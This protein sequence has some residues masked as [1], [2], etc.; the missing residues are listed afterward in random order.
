MNS[1]RFLL[2][3][4]VAGVVY[5]LLGWVVYGMLL[6]S[7]MTDNTLPGSMRAENEMI[8]WALILGNLASG[9]LLAYI[10]GK[11]GASTV[12]SGAV[13]GLVV[14]LLM[15]LAFDLTMYGT[16]KI[17]ANAQF[18]GVDVIA[19]AAMSAITGAVVGWVYGMRKAVVP[20]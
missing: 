10:L 13:I 8:W 17:I 1:S 2:A 5:F 11:A 16:S 4:I 9:F 20:A 15:A 18:I 6:T 3:G 12:A 14:G 7:Y 19:S